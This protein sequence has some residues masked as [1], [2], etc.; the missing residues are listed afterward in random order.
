MATC[1]DAAG[2]S[3]IISR[4]WDNVMGGCAGTTE[5]F[6]NGVGTNADVSDGSLLTGPV[7]CPEFTPKAG[8]PRKSEG[9]DA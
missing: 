1:S 7:G 5:D 6:C 8:L 2:V 9:D 4:F 3:G